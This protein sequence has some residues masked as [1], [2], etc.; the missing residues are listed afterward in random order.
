MIDRNYTK[1]TTR[2]EKWDYDGSGFLIY[3]ADAP[4][5]T[6]GSDA[7][8]NINKYTNNGAGSPTDKVS[9]YGAWDNRATTVTYA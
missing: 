5:G 4:Q 1:V 6:V 7:F 9:G 2:C 8:W 3:A